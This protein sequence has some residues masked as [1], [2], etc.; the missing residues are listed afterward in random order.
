MKLSLPGPAVLFALCCLVTH[1]CTQT[2][3][4]YYDA[5][6]YAVEITPYEIAYADVIDYVECCVVFDAL[7]LQSYAGWRIVAIK[8][9]NPDRNTAIS[10][11][12]EVYA[13]RAGIANPDT[14]VSINAQPA[15]IT[16][17]N[18][19]TIP[20]ETPVVIAEGTDYWAGY[21]VSAQ[22]GRFPL[23]VG[24]ELSYNNSYIS[25]GDVFVEVTHNW[26]IRIIAEK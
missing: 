2:A 19:R 23:A 3:E 14:L 6:E 25:T 17:L 7:T 26:V 18:W 21:S 10:Y 12:P 13:A 11:T 8:I 4:L 9:F 20:L 5:S 24:S 15:E 16:S 1:G 22:P